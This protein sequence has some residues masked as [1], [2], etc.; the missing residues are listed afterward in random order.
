M[1]RTARE[2]R[3]VLQAA[4]LEQPDTDMT[5][6]S[7]QWVQWYQRLYT[8]SEDSPERLAADWLEHFGYLQWGKA[9]LAEAGYDEEYLSYLIHCII[10]SAENLGR[11]QERTWWR[12]NPVPGTETK[13]TPE[14]KSPEKLALA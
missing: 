2:L 7:A 11:I 4:G 10:D 13:T 14:G 5:E 12:T 9:Q 6:D 3:E 1:E 8:Y